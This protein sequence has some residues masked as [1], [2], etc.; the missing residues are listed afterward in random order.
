MQQLR[1]E[2]DE[3]DH[4]VRA[5]VVHTIRAYAS[6]TTRVLSINRTGIQS[7]GAAAPQMQLQLS[8]QV[9][10]AG[11]AAAE[12]AWRC[13]EASPLLHAAFDS[14]SALYK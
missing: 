8:G 4:V 10:A 11:A 9:A 3:F 7:R 5:C 1:C 2:G 6:S 13:V 12:C 14:E